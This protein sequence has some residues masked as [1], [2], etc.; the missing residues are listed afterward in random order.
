[1]VFDRDGNI[2]VGFGDQEFDG[3]PVPGRRRNGYCS[4][5]CRLAHQKARRAEL[6]EQLVLDD[7]GR[8]E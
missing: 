3:Q 2:I 7:P 5:R 1:M 4:I 6:P 8:A